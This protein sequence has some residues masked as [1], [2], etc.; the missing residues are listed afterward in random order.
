MARDFLGHP[1]GKD[2]CSLAILVWTLRGFSRQTISAISLIS[3]AI[4]CAVT[5]SF[6]RTGGKS[7]RTMFFAQELGGNHDRDIKRIW[8]HFWRSDRLILLL[9]YTGIAYSLGKP[10]V[11]ITQDQNDMPFDIQHIRHIHYEF[12]PRGMSIFEKQLKETLSIELAECT[13]RPN[14]SL[15]R[16]GGLALVLNGKVAGRRPV[17]QALYVRVRSRLSPHENAQVT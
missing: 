3:L 5:V 14:E 17:A 7:T 13:T 4:D 9:L 8:S 16:S 12:T 1:E 11:L 15:N 6:L 2:S 10:V